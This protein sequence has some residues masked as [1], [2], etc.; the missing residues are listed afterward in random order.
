[1][2]QSKAKL[3]QS[4]P[5]RKQKTQMLKSWTLKTHFSSTNLREPNRIL[6]AKIKTHIFDM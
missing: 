3:K 1:M 6:Y 2:E 5:A 4:R